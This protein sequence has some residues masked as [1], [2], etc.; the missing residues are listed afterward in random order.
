MHE[1][2]SLSHVRWECKYHVVIIPKYRR[3]VF[4]GKSRRQIGAILRELCK[5]RGVELLEG[6]CMPDHIHMCIPPKYSAAHTVGFL[7][8]RSAVRIHSDLL[9]ERRM[10]GL[11]FWATGYLS[12]AN[13]IAVRDGKLSRFTR[14]FRSRD[15]LGFLVQGAFVEHP[16]SREILTGLREDAPHV[17]ERFTAH[18]RPVLLAFGQG[19]GLSESDAQDAAQETLVAFLAGWREGKYEGDK[20]RL[21]QW[22]LRIAR[23]KILYFLRQ[24]GRVVQPPSLSGTA[25]LDRI[26]DDQAMSQVW[27]REWK[28]WL[29]AKCIEEVR[30]QVED[31][32]FRVFELLTLQSWPVDRVTQELSMT[33][34]AALKANRRVLTRIRELQKEWEQE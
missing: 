19:L 4:Y 8:G 29:L 6:H 33:T 23:N 3:R 22:L 18:Y 31:R 30:T 21:R 7:K 10:A 25:F 24:R 27:E 12:Q 20:G 9:H 2:G 34:N 11:Q 16:S 5:Q 26:S 13:P 15:S 28:R 1:L 32:T 14:I 17:W